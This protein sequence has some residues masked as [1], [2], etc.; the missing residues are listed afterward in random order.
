MD[1]GNSRYGQPD[2]NSHHHDWTRDVRTNPYGYSTQKQQ[3]ATARP[4]YQEPPPIFVDPTFFKVASHQAGQ[5]IVGA[6]KMSQ[7][8]GQDGGPGG[9]FGDPLFRSTPKIPNPV[10]TG[11]TH[12]PKRY[13]SY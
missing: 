5:N 1:A 3:I 2:T 11:T 10:P 4:V 6:V 8:K 9:N 13:G 7:N 12:M